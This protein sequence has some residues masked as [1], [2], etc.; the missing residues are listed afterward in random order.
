M[1]FLHWSLLVAQF[2][3]ATDFFLRLRLD[4][5][6]ETMVQLLTLHKFGQGAGGQK[7]K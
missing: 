2:L 3:L 6:I 1:F 7:R 4:I 5:E